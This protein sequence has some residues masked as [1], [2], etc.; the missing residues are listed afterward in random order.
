MQPQ[1]EG[2]E[3][4]D[5]IEI[6]AKARLPQKKN[7]EDYY[8]PRVFCFSCIQGKG[9]KLRDTQ[10]YCILAGQTGRAYK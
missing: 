8:T 10:Q 6:E 4:G 9:L 1:S 3:P 2:R 5:Y 7:G